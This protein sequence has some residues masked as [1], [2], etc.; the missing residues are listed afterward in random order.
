[1]Y[2]YHALINALSAH[3]IHINLNMIFYLNRTTTTTT[4]KNKTGLDT[5]ARALPFDARGRPW[6][7]QVEGGVRRWKIL[8]LKQRSRGEK[9]LVFYARV[10]RHSVRDCCVAVRICVVGRIFGLQEFRRPVTFSAVVCFRVVCS[11]SRAAR[12]A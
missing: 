9:Q 5:H 6:R 7:A 12:D 10:V 8:V 1:M 11:L 2:I 4:N 3:M